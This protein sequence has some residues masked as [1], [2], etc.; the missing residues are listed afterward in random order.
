MGV[1][2]QPQFWQTRWFPLALAA[3]LVLGG[4]LALRVRLAAL[5]ARAQ[6]LE[7]QVQE[8]TA[9]L[10]EQTRRL[11]LAD[12]E[13]SE[14]LMQLRRQSERFEQLA[15]EDALTGLPNRRSLDQALLER[16]EAAR[17]SGSALTVAVADIDH[18]KRINDTFS[19]PVG[20]EVIRWVAD[21]LRTG[22][23]EQDVVGRYGG[24]E[25]LLLFPGLEAGQAATVC[26]RLRQAVTGSDLERRYQGLKVTLSIGLADRADRP[27]HEKLLAAA[28]AM[29]YRA[30][31]EGRDRVRWEAPPTSLE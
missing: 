15:R 21:V 10:R 2:I 31:R 17:A 18:F 29:L 24:E 22:V 6:E 8:R 26:E 25:F 27:G 3:L 20:D 23:R 1:A 28:D 16:Y 4:Y 12:Q 30:K 14:L 9:A 19:H 11:E 5:R 7:V 13:K